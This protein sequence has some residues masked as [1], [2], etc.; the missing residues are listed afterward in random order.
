MKFWNNEKRLKMIELII[1]NM[2][3]F[4]DTLNLKIFI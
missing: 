1:D 3:T 2:D 4:V